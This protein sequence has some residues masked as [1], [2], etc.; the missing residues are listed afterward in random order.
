MLKNIPWNFSPRTVTLLAGKREIFLDTYPWPFPFSRED[1]G[2]AFSSPG[3][4]AW[5]PFFLRC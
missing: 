3:R 5:P 1:A 2:G 4:R